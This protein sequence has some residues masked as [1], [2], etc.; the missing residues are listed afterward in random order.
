MRISAE[1]LAIEAEA[2]GFR[3]DVLETAVQLLSLLSALT[4]HPA[5]HGKLALKGGTALNLFVFKAPRLS[6]DIDLNYVGTGHLAELQNERPRLE[7][8]VESVCRREYSVVR[9]TRSGHAGGSWSLRYPS[10]GGQYGRLEVDINFMYRLPLWPVTS[11]DSIGLGRWHA[12]S[13]P[14]VDL[15]ELAAGRLAALLDRGRA[16]DLFD[17]RLIFRMSSLDSERLRIAFVVYGAMVRRDSR[18]VSVADVGFDAT[19]LTRQLTPTLHRDALPRD[20]DP[21]E[22]ATTLVDECRSGLSKLLPLHAAELEFLDRLLDHGEV[23]SALLTANAD[24]QRR[25]R[26]QPLLDWK[27]QHVRQFR[28]LS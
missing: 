13:I 17:S 24:L 3:P 4:R 22:Y 23:E 5:L 11:M 20:A 19:E 10:A 9:R 14:V 15:H 28:G 25:N 27:A 12:T 8:A 16:R 7:A 1:A 26:S 21:K 6:V 2:T 18:T